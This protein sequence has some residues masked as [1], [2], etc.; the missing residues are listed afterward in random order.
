MMKP[1]SSE[2]GLVTRAEA[3]R[4]AR[5][6]MLLRQDLALRSLRK[7]GGEAAAVARKRP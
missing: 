4:A 3:Q 7:L 1:E 2:T 6:E 5:L